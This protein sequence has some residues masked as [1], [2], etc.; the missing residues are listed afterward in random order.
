MT[1]KAKTH[2]YGLCA[3][4]FLS[5]AFPLTRIAL[6]CFSPNV[7]GALRCTLAS[8]V[9]LGFGKFTG[10][11]RPFK[12]FHLPLFVLSGVLG[13]GVYLIFFNLGLQ[14]ITAATA[15]IIIS[16]TPIM[17]AFAASFFY[18]EK[19]SKIGVLSIIGAFAGVLIILLWK[20]V[21]SINTGALWMLAAAVFFCAYNILS[22]RFIKMGSTSIDVVTYSIFTGALMLSF[23]LPQAYR[24][25]QSAELKHIAVFVYL[26]IFTTAGGYFLLGKGLQVAEKTS[27]LTNYMFVIP[28]MASILGY[29]LLGETLTAGT[30]I[31]GF[32]I[33]VSI[34]VFALKGKPV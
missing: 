6:E 10:L 18:G 2:M 27:D 20:G 7:F 9:L 24:E 4:F 21:F 33:A 11:R 28:L 15:S 29:L 34:V 19:L 8:V 12:L 1:N 25:L 16:T 26:S 13:F 17:T 23:L 31:G 22:K 5:C 14:S 3:A 32:L 30:A